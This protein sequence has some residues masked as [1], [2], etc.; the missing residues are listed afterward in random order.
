MTHKSAL[1][2]II[3]F[4]TA[5]PALAQQTQMPP[6]DQAQ[7]QNQ[8]QSQRISP[9]ER[10]DANKDG[11]ITREEVRVARG[12][13]FARLDTNR[14]G[15]LVREEMPPPQSRRADRKM[16]DRGGSNML[17]RA[18]A[19]SDGT[20]TKAE[21][22]AA[23]ARAQT[24]S[25]VAR[26]ARREIMFGRLDSNRDGTVTRAEAEAARAV[27]PSRR[28]ENGQPPTPRSP[29]GRPNPD[30]NNDQK[31]SLV[32]WLARPDP[33]FE[34]GDANKDGRV[35]RE[36]AAAIVRAERGEGGRRPRPW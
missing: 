21:F 22:D 10:A 28:P 26:D 31:I 23:W 27:M 35:T 14:D 19:N 2:A 33:L 25:A 8:G 16:G 17:G 7:A 9:F 11:V 12:A 18:D 4:F 29:D 1:V 34:R 20:V 24:A 15:F 30:T 6:L 36:E 3:L 5:S 32:E 13:T